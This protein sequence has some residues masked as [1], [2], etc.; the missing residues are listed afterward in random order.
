MRWS[1][2]FWLIFCAVFG[3]AA[4][5]VAAYVFSPDF[6]GWGAFFLLY[7][8]VMAAGALGLEKLM[9][10]QQGYSA[11]IGRKEGC[12]VSRGRLILYSMMC[13]CPFYLFIFVFSLIPIVAY[14]VWFIT[15]FP[16]LVIVLFPLG[17]LAAVWRDVRQPRRIFWSM[18]AGVFAL[19]MIFGSLIGGGLPL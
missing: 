8:C 19:T 11:R 9:D 13:S 17:E 2:L 10:M 15:V 5:L 7:G 1:R 16:C 14:Q 4:V 3:L 6:W 12:R 18:Q